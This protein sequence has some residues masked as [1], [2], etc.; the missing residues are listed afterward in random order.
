MSKTIDKNE[1]RR[2]RL[3]ADRGRGIAGMGR[4]RRFKDRRKEASRKAC[5]GRQD[6]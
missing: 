4:V 1:L 6:A 5:R 3:A 2:V